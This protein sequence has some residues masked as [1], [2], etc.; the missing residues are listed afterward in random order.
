MAEVSLNKKSVF[1]EL[2]FSAFLD[3]LTEEIQALYLSDSVPWV[4]GYSGGKDSSAIVSLIWLALQKLPAE[5]RE[6]PVHVISTD[7]L[8]ENPI[9]ASWVNMSLVRMGEAAEQQELPI[10]PHRLTPEVSDTFWV[11]LIGK[12]Y[13]APRNKFRWCTERLK[14]K[15][16]NSFIT[17]VVRENGEAILVLGTR[18]AES[19]RRSHNMSL[20]AK[21]AIRERLT[22]NA[23]LPNSLVY[24]PIEDWTNDD[25]WLFLMR[26]PNPWGHSN[27][28]LMGMYR[29]ASADGECPL[30]VD[31]TTPSCG[32]SRFGCWVCTLVDQDKS[33]A[34]M[35]QNDVE[36]DWMLPMLELRNEL[37]FRS[38]E[39]RA[40]ELA[41]RDYRRITGKLTSY[42]SQGE[43]QP[44]PGPYKPEA[45]EYWLRRVLETQEFL[46][47]NAPES[48]GEI[49]LITK[50][51]LQEIRRI[52]VVEKHEIEDR[53]PVIYQE[54][55]G[56]PYPG[57]KIDDHQV[58][59]TEV[60]ALLRES[61]PEDPDGMHYEMLR[62]LIDV[63]RRYRTMTRRRGLFEE[64]ENE[65]EKCFWD[66]RE[67]AVDFLRAHAANKQEVAE[68]I[69]NLDV[70]MMSEATPRDGSASASASD[71]STGGQDQ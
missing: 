19:S 33:M 57:Q 49:E 56:R 31:T 5:Q 62:N 47:E 53:V 39:A 2:G 18:K 22:P 32:N 15:P 64:I 27:K 42:E 61:C 20:H 41:R 12:G 36:K 26:L 59:D 70:R 17:R 24:T 51:E 34:A 3:R 8:V 6:K 40:R 10:V 68:H 7:T 21:N 71:Q 28:E 58:F 16:S 1:E 63:E 9:V 65:I 11:N 48:M 29:G 23:S 69:E 14:I 30:V 46:R 66:G 50:E 55:T 25:V 60:L 43:V 35:I 52:W 45:R 67:D 44:V 4:V 37:D 13:P 38:E 54:V